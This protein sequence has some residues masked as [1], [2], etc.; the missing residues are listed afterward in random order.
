[1]LKNKRLVHRFVD[2]SSRMLISKAK[3]KKITCFLL[4]LFCP[5]VFL[6]VQQLKTENHFRCI[7]TVMIII[8]EGRKKRKKKG[9]G[10]MDLFTF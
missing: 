10:E 2:K 9:G 1:M 5:G 7:M 6:K 8:S 4:R 3:N